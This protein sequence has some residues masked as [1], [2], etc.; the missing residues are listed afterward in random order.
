MR[1][2]ILVIAAVLAAMTPASASAQVERCENTD[3]CTTFAPKKAAP[4]PR[5]KKSTGAQST[6]C[7]G[8]RLE[9]QSD[10]DGAALAAQKFER[11]CSPQ[12]AS[13]AQ[14]RTE[15]SRCDARWEAA[16]SAKTVA[17][18]R[19]FIEECPQHEKAPDAARMMDTNSQIKK[20]E[21]RRRLLEANCEGYWQQLQFNI[22]LDNMRLFLSRCDTTKNSK[23]ARI[24]AN[25]IETRPLFF[26]KVPPPSSAVP[27][28]GLSGF[29][30]AYADKCDR[31]EGGACA[32]LA[33][34]FR[35]GSRA[36]KNNLWAFALMV[37]A[38]SN[39]YPDACGTVADHLKYP[40]VVQ[41]VVVRDFARAAM[42]ARYGCDRGGLYACLEYAK[43]YEFGL[44]VG[45]NIN[46]AVALYER[47]CAF[48]Q[49]NGVA[50]GCYYA[51]RIWSEGGEGIEA[52]PARA[53][54]LIDAG[55]Q[56]DPENDDL[57]ALSEALD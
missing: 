44:G 39:N 9:A 47:S 37:R 26:Q 53:Q 42:I 10:R 38:C 12:Q 1:F 15:N 50:F 14:Q 25:E 57:I 33:H 2:L 13:Y 36:P 8:L 21:E 51:A 18:L 23:I 55:L 20:E 34:A 4:K 19:V 56:L 49:S 17:A 3:T 30:F 41:G 16:N 29:N 22:T 11:D 48:G 31:G 7:E 46:S 24:F 40:D 27:R 45:R 52:D 35:E 5:Q 32:A 43:A 28:T 54:R 6:R